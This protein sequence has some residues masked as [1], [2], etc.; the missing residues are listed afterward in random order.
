MLFDDPGSLDPEAVV[1][2]HTL[3]TQALVRERQELRRVFALREPP[4]SYLPIH[5]DLGATEAEI[6]NYFRQCQE[7]LDVSAVF[8]LI[9]AA[10]GRIRLD[11]RERVNAHQDQLG[12]R[13]KVLLDKVDDPW[14][15]ALYDDGIMDAWKARVALLAG[16]TNAERDRIRGAIGKLRELLTVR[17]WVA[18]GRYFQLKRR[19]TAYPPILI[20]AA[21]SELFAALAKVCEQDPAMMQ[22]H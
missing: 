10:E 15:V 8:N 11:L 3:C 4:P 12:M 16:L 5:L 2:W 19:I 6:D 22:F 20:A 1:W 21:I 17:H 7:E 9:A 13:F 18:H 14:K